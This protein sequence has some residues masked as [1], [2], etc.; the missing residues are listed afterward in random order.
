VFEDIFECKILGTT[1]VM[2]CVRDGQYAFLIW[3]EEI[4]GELP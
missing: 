3:K 1:D 2:L 4:A